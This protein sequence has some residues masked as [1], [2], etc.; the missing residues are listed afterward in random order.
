MKHI[1]ALFSG[2]A[3]AVL[4]LDA[5][6]ALAGAYDGI[7]L[8]LRVV[9]PSLFPFFFLSI[10]LGNGLSGRRI[11]FLAK[12]GRSLG[13]PIGAEGILISA[14]LGGY[15]VGAQSV[16]EL[17]RS[18]CLCRQDA[19]RMLAFCSNAGPAFLF[20][21]AGALFSDIRTVWLLW[22]IHIVSALLVGW[23]LPGKSQNHSSVPNV[24]PLS[25]T[26]CLSR[27]IR[28]M[29]GVCG[30]VVLFRVL[31]NVLDRWLFWALP[32]AWNVTISGILELSNGCIGLKSIES[33]GLR[34][35]LCAVFLAFGGLCV[36]MQT[37]SV[38]SSCGLGLY[39]PGKLLHAIFSF[40]L[41]AAAGIFLFHDLAFPVPV[42]PAAVV[43]GILCI[44]F[45]RKTQNK[46]SIP[47]AAG[48]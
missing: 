4:I 41:A 47:A 27:A 3:M 17:H 2:L 30:W 38:V 42:L 10:L 18:G 43:L 6:T 11:P 1:R 22:G 20:G 44:L 34:F 13:I 45:L 24:P 33:E 9:V 7:E 23:F 19:R 12:L 46:G 8:C 48:V 32:E 16:G 39:L 37:A 31:L 26:E 21:M 14:F 40:L 25:P 15:P 28:A 36:T 35:I 29:A 5:K